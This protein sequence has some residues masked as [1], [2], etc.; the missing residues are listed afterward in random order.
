[1]FFDAEPAADTAPSSALTGDDS[2][3]PA[4]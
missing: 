2:A 1:V 4:A 3:G